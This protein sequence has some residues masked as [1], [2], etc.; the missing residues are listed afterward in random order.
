M[1]TAEQASGP[2]R[3]FLLHGEKCFFQITFHQKKKKKGV[4]S[5]GMGF[6]VTSGNQYDLAG[7]RFLDTDEQGASLKNFFF[8]IIRKAQ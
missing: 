5:S 4:E 8:F 1:E 2:S 3:W 7:E 6:N